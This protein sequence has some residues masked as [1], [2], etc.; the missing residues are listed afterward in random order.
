MRSCFFHLV[1]AIYLSVFCC[2]SA[3]NDEKNDVITITCRAKGIE[4]TLCRELVQIWSKKHGIDVEIIA[5]PNASGD[6]FSL[7][8]QLLH[9]GSS[10]VD[11]YQIDSVWGSAF[12]EHFLDLSEYVEPNYLQNFFEPIADTLHHNGRLIALP[13]YTDVGIMYYRRDLLEKYNLPRP[14]TMEELYE[15]ALKIQTAERVYNPNMYGFVFHAKAQES[16]TCFALE[17]ISAF[18][19]K[20]IADDRLCLTDFESVEAMRFI[21]LCMRDIVPRSVLN[22]SEEETRGIFQSGNAVFM[23]NWPYAWALLNSEKSPLCGKVEVMSIPPSRHNGKTT[24]ALGGWH[25]S[26]SKYSKNPQKAISL[27]KFLTSRYSQKVRALRASYAPTYIDLYSDIEIRIQNSFFKTLAL[28]LRNAAIRP[29]RHVRNYNL[30]SAVIYN[31]V[32]NILA[33][34]VDAEDGM[35]QCEQELRPLLVSVLHITKSSSAKK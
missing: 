13:L 16:L 11:V 31:N 17:L 30:A 33:H 29:S 3:C 35:E 9:I 27:V 24:G 32:H 10:D 4:M 23:R 14:T 8:Q 15:T 22:Y 6:C 19:G 18:R 1:H 12:A 7:Y 2:L 34:K 28:S 21:A 20:I 25:M 26:V 5:L